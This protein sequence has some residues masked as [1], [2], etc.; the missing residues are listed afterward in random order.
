MLDVAREAKVSKPTVSRALSDNP[1]VTKETK[2]HIIETARKLGYVVNRNAQKLR[3]KNTN[4][5]AVSFDFLSHRQNR[6]SDPF[7][8]DLLA[9][10]S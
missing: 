9:G 8:F 4:T 10:I 5:V 3:H 7:I 2:E 6:I 1:L